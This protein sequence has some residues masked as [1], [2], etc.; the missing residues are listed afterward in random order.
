MAK[1]LTRIPNNSHHCSGRRHFLGYPDEGKMKILQTGKSTENDADIFAASTALADT[2]NALG[3][4]RSSSRVDRAG[5]DRR[6]FRHRHA[7]PSAKLLLR[8]NRA[9]GYH[10]GAGGSIRPD[11]SG[12]MTSLTDSISSTPTVSVISLCPSRCSIG[13]RST[14]RGPLHAGSIPHKRPSGF[15]SHGLRSGSR[16]DCRP[17]RN[18]LGIH[19]ASRCGDPAL[20][21]QSGICDQRDALG[22]S[23][24]AFWR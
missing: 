18:H 9:A 13:T 2:E 8:R 6:R 17:E 5:Q 7:R 3:D 11:H 4:Q 23:K 10:G 15:H 20:R 19:R 12:E 21:R 14:G 22:D 24:S 16:P 1:E